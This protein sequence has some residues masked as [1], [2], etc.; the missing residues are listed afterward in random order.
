[1]YSWPWTGCRIWIFKGSCWGSHWGLLPER[2]RLVS[3]SGGCL[4]P[5][6]WLWRNPLEWLF[7]EEM[8]SQ[9][10]PW[11]LQML[12][13]SPWKR[14]LPEQLCQPSFPRKEGKASRAP[15]A[16]P[17]G[18]FQGT[19]PKSKPYRKPNPDRE[20][21][22]MEKQGGKE[23]KGKLRR[24]SRSKRF[25]RHS[26]WG[27]VLLCKGRSWSLCRTVSWR[28]KTV[29]AFFLCSENS[30]FPPLGPEPSL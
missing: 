5:I 19:T 20:E 15:S 23:K 11:R 24:A 26:L 4:G 13:G 10:P 1:M 29:W 28:V 21:M 30:S 8:L 16:N 18:S 6:R 3:N 25:K 22:T 9:L 14:W 12:G 27:R 17:G 7:C 2:L